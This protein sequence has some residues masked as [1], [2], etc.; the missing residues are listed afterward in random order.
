MGAHNGPCWCTP[1]AIVLHVFLCR[2]RSDTPYRF[3][4]GKQNALIYDIGSKVHS[5][6]I[7]THLDVPRFWLHSEITF[8]EIC[9]TVY[10]CIILIRQRSR[11]RLGERRA[12][13]SLSQPWPMGVLSARADDAG[14]DVIFYSDSVVD[15]MH[16]TIHLTAAICLVF[17]RYSVK[18]RERKRASA[19]GSTWWRLSGYSPTSSC[20]VSDQPQRCIQGG[21]HYEKYTN[22]NINLKYLLC[23]S[24]NK[25]LPVYKST[26]S[27]KSINS[28]PQFVFVCTQNHFRMFCI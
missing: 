7:K 26:R 27:N 28:N 8:M 10:V 4:C 21:G 24:W 3:Y 15:T 2:Q 19:T 5:V 1:I 25:I 18:W 12:C 14:R 22:R 9:V 20:T 16:E 17:L 11:P 23:A 6:A 13:P